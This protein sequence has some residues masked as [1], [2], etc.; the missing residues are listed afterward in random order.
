[1]E[2][3]GNIGKH[4]FVNEELRKRSDEMMANS[5]KKIG[6][7]WAVWALVVIALII[8]RIQ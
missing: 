2:D 7:I 6:I 1:M 8:T 3:Y 5:M 4:S